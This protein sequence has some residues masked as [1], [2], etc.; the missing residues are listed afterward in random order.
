RPH[1]R[2]AAP[3]ELPAGADLAR[4][5]PDALL[6]ARDA[7]V[8]SSSNVSSAGTTGGDPGSSSNGVATP[9]VTTPSHLPSLVAACVSARSP[10]GVVISN[11][12]LVHR[13]VSGADGARG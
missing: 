4:R 12:P 7:H 5:E 3:G 1:E 11:L 13:Q 2:L 6:D 8:P 10:A 9:P